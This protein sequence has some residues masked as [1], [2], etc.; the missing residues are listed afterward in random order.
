MRAG[1]S[2]SLVLV[3]NITSLVCFS[4]T[5]MITPTCVDP[6]LWAVSGNVEDHFG[7]TRYNGSS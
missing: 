7:L 4:K 6:W 1:F 3:G 5:R 2:K